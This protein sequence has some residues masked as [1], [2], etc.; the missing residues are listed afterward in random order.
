MSN[1][2]AEI[3][4]W[5][6]PASTYAYLSAMRIEELAA[7]AGCRLIWRPF[8][9]GPIFRAQGWDT[10]PF[11]I[12]EAKGRYMVRDIERI[13]KERGL[14]FLLPERF[15]AASL[16]AARVCLASAEQDW[17][18]A[19]VRA[20]FKAEFDTRA[21]VSDAAVLRA[22]LAEARAP[23]PD[24]ALNKAE[25]MQ[26]KQ[27]LRAQ[28][29]RAATLGIFGAPTFTTH[30]GELFWGDDRLEQAL[31]WATNINQKNQ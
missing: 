8:L 26:N 18:G 12:Y 11:N 5:F 2:P 7:A 3:E 20:M 17:I 16:F 19:F 10:S 23:D 14:A 24:S 29:D 31:R 9:L 21:D 28:T 30:D 4:F 13:A 25:T 6:D 15:P 27:G 1:T 22:C